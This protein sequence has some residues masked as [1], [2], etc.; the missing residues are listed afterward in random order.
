MATSSSLLTPTPAATV[1]TSSQISR[2]EPLKPTPVQSHTQTQK[3]S[4]PTPTYTPPP[5]RPKTTPSMPPPLQPQT[6]ATLNDSSTSG[7][8]FQTSILNRTAGSSGPMSWSS[9][10]LTPSSSTGLTAGLTGSHSLN[11]TQSGSIP[12]PT[13]LTGSHNL[14]ATQT[15]STGL[16]AGL[17]GSHSLTA[18]QTGSTGLTAGLTGSHS[19]TATQTGSTGLTAGLT[20]SQN[21]TAT[22]TGSTTSGLF[23]GMQLGSSLPPANQTTAPMTGSFVQQ[24]ESP[25]STLQNQQLLSN[26]SS[27][28][29]NL[30]NQRAQTSLAPPLIPSQSQQ[31]NVNTAMEWSSTIQGQSPH[32]TNIQGSFDTHGQSTTLSQNLMGWSSNIAARPQPQAASSA[33]GWSQNIGTS[34][35]QGSGTGMGM[36]WTGGMQ[37]V[38]G[39]QPVVG[40]PTAASVMMGGGQ[41]LVPQNTSSVARQPSQQQPAP[42]ANPFADLSFLS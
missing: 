31:D 11:A 1:T 22:Q 13:R 4:S 24:H 41:P 39:S 5:P 33:T 35:P 14:T 19:L 38:G 12:L 30:T 6:A 18:T 8:V 17:T 25:T 7:S 37:A 27:W 29:P 40:Q 2:S 23:S 16:T 42:G 36:G 21:L 28:Q 10:L 20:G 26:T 15:G 32:S 9:N 34:Q 3:P